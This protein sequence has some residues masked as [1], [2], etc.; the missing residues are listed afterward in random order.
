[1]NGDSELA[2]LL[3]EAPRTP[4]PA[5]RFDVFARM[6]ARSRRRAAR[7]RAA[8]YVA[9]FAALGL[10]FPAAQAIGLTLAEAGPLLMSAGALGLAYALAVLGPGAALMRSRHLLRVRI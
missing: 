5:F 3:G 10:V 2:N 1:M 4:D 9:G 6:A 8:I 7:Q